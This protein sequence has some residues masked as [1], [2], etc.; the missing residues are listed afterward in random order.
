MVYADPVHRLNSEGR[1]ENIDNSIVASDDEL[2]TG[3]A[4]VKFSKKLTNNGTILKVHENNKK[5]EFA[6][7]GTV[8]KTDG[9]FTN[10]ES[11]ISEKDSKLEQLKNVDDRSSKVVYEDVFEG[12]DL[13]YILVSNDIKE[14]IIVK[15]RLEDYSYTFSLKLKG[16]IAKLENGEIVLYE[17]DGEKAVYKIPAP[18]MYDSAGNRSDEVFYTLTD[19][20]NGKYEFTV[21][22]DTNWINDSDRAFPVVIDPSLLDVGQIKDTYAD[23]SYPNTNYGADYE[24]WVSTTCETYLAFDTPNLP[25]ESNITGAYLEVPCYYRADNYNYITLGAYQITSDW[26][27][28]GVT[29]NN[30]PGTM[31]SYIDDTYVYADGAYE[32]SPAIALFTVKNYVQSW[33]SGTNNYGFAIKRIGG[34]NNSIILPSREKLQS[35]ARLTINYS[36]TNNL[37]EGVYNISKGT[38]NIRMKSYIPDSLGW[39]LQHN[40][41]S[42]SSSDLENLFKIAYRPDYNDYVIRSMLD[43][44]LIMCPSVIEQAP[45]TQRMSTQDYMLSTAYTWNITPTSDGY[46][47]I[48][49]TSNG[50][51]YYIGSFSSFEDDTLNFTTDANDTSTKWKFNK[52]TGN[53][54]EDVIFEDFVYSIDVGDTYQFAAYMLSSKVGHNGPVRYYVTDTDDTGTTKATINEFT[55]VFTAINPGNVYLY[56]TFDGAPWVWCVT[57]SIGGTFVNNV[58]TNLRSSVGSPTCIPCA[59]TNL[60][61]YWC[62]N[63]GYYQFGCEDAD[64]QSNRANEVQVAMQALVEGGHYANDNIQLGFDVFSHIEG[65]NEYV[66]TATNRW[67]RDN[68]FDWNMIV[69][70]IN[71]GRPLLLGFAYGPYGGGHMTVCV[72]YD[73]SGDTKNV[74]VS[75][76]INDEYIIHEFEI[77]GYNDFISTVEVQIS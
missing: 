6:L 20:G 8:N 64:S 19:N 55:G 13:E 41:T 9:I 27:E 35:Y 31:S 17:A 57:I 4:R 52:Y 40:K 66:L 21:T 36:G 58:P 24:L 77:D 1:W 74:Y 25:L 49:Y 7:M 68:A 69:S 26:N 3:D 39:V 10:T 33:Y 2:S 11:K 30:R 60:A 32:N 75:D 42:V 37:P 71:A 44:S 67:A 46:H 51:T 12:V 76:A 63:N 15:K 47:Q 72:G 23:A 50:I 43:S 18:F 28:Y 14:N 53:V 48:S 54:I 56:V 59:V 5:V 61:S 70:E 29:W 16:L 34:T 38:T 45:I 62:I 65:D 73:I 22:A